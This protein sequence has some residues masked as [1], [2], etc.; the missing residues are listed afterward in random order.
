MQHDLEFAIAIG[1]RNCA[2]QLE[3]NLIGAFGADGKEVCF[4]NSDFVRQAM[5]AM[6]DTIN[7][8]FRSNIAGA[9]EM[10]ISAGLSFYQFN[11]RA[12]RTQAHDNLT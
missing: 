12:A 3:M 10:T 7:A 6:K 2:N 4:N 1:E 8:G 11:S 9:E 5:L